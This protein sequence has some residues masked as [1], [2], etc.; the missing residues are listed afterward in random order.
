MSINNAKISVIG[1]GYVGSTIVHAL[2]LQKIASEIVLVDLNNDKAKAE[3]LDIG[4]ATSALGDVKV[5]HGEYKDTSDSDIVI[6]TAGIGPKYG[7]TRLDIVNKNLKVFKSMIPEIVKYNPNAILLVVSNP[8]DILTYVTYKLSGFP[9]NRVLGSGTVLDT[10]RLKY[11]IEKKFNI[12]SKDIDTLIIGEHGDSQVPLWSQTNI[13]G[14]NIDSYFKAINEDFNDEIKKEIG[15][16]V[17][18]SAYDI[19]QGKGY[20][21]FG[22]ALAVTRIVKAIVNDENALLPISALYNGEYEIDNVYIGAPCMIGETG[23]KKIFQIPINQ[24]ES[25]QLKA[26]ANSLKSLIK[27]LDV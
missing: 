10:L 9:Q 18:N 6:I 19:L 25:S 2:T 16:Q 15:K 24:E 21:N 22:V 17:V 13:H 14:I 12:D 20:T 8:V 23:L 3:A 26:S 5:I 11:T 4:H 27:D 7:E 1:A